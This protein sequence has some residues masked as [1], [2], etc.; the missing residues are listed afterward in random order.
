MSKHAGKSD[1]AAADGPASTGFEEAL[2]E[3]EQIIRRIESGEVGLEQ[4]IAQY[5]RGVKLIRHCRGVLDKVEHRVVELTAQMQAG[6]GGDGGE[7]G[8]VA[9]APQAP[10][11][12]AKPGRSAGTGTPADEDVPF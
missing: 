3:V 7:A 11:R 8:G 9:D 10:S 2:A 6:V 4:S 12:G 1:P 5:E